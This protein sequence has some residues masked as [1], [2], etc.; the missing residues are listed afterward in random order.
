MLSIF[1]YLDYRIF[2]KDFYEKK[3]N[4]NSFYSYRYMGNKVGVDPGNIVK[5]FQ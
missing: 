5:I 3:K 4:E 2:L 1:D